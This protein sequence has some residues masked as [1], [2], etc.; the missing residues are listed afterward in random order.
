MHI[1]LQPAL[2]QATLIFQVADLHAAEVEPK[3]LSAA[4]LPSSRLLPYRNAF[5]KTVSPELK[6]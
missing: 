2:G 4:E 1:P 5:E 6:S 3:G